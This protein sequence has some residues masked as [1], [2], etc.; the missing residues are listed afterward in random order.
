M[1]TKM[2]VFFGE[3][4]SVSEFLEK[5]ICCRHGGSQLKRRKKK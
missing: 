1:K 2:R 3:V 5:E 4:G